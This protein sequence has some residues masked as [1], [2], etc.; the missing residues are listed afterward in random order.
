MTDA[1]LGSFRRNSKSLCDSLPD[2]IAQDPDPE[3]V[4][5]YTQEVMD[6]ML[7]ESRERLESLDAAAS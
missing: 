2:E 7:R 6:Q 4:Q 5:D 3:L 1:K